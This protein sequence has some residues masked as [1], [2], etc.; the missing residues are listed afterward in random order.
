VRD[1]VL[2][3]S[4]AGATRSRGFGWLVAGLERSA[5]S[6]PGVLAVL[7]YHRVDDPARS[8]HLYPGLVSALP[9]EFEEQIRLLASRYRPL[10]L[11]K[12]LAVRRGETDLPLR[13]VLVTFD[14]G[15]L[16]FAAEAWP[17]L[18]R[19]EVPVVLFVPTAYPGTARSF[20]WDRLYR[21]ITTSGSQ[22]IT[23]PLGEL[24]LDS[25][26]HRQE[27]FRR[28][29]GLVKSLPHEEAM[30]L[31]DDL[32]G[33]HG[34]SSGQSAVLDWDEL[35]QLRSEGVVIA[36]HSRTHPL[37]DQLSPESAREEIVGSLE[38]LTREIGTAPKVFAYPAGGENAEV[39]GVLA[40]EGFEL[41]FTTERGTNDIGEA[42]W[43]G[44]RRINVGRASTAPLL[45]AQL[46]PWWGR[47][48]R[49]KGGS[50][51]SYTLRPT[52]HASRR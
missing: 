7:T 18:R 2:R 17:I 26:S 1:S 4:V 45:R 34:G 10:S 19:Y 50:R 49:T 48:R 15:Y 32:C 30:A 16:D 42:N 52:H 47:P 43:L 35:R 33:A 31:V 37:L 46:L 13:S 22:A 36:P 25:S 38:D 27:A 6:R 11:E 28:L 51:T 14:D 23:T 24:P 44:L 39:A 3:R 40:D 8:P 9:S 5:R 21:S 12:L 41:A 20:W 29:R